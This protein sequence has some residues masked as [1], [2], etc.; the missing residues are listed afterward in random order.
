MLFRSG[1]RGYS[2]RSA[3]G[4]ALKRRRLAGQTA[5][6]AT[7]QAKINAA[8][9]GWAE[10][11]RASQPGSW[12]PAN[13]PAIPMAMPEEKIKLNPNGRFRWLVNCATTGEIDTAHSEKAIPPR[14]A[15][16]I[17]AVG[18]TTT[19]RSRP[20]SGANSRQ[21]ASVARKPKR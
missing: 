5:R 8:C 11:N 15:S 2:L 17:S 9:L 16:T 1:L 19:A 3:G 14:N 10:W 21:P 6:T 18:P 20:I 13:E 4:V 12:P 7:A